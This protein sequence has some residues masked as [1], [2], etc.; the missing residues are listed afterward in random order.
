MKVVGFAGWSNSGKTTLITG[1]IAA[2]KAGGARVSVVKHAHQR[3]DIDHPGKDSWR[4]R[5]AGAYEVLIASGRRM[6]KMRE[7]EHEM[8]LDVHALL[9]ELDAA[10]WV[11]VEGFRHADLPKI[12]VWREGRADRGALYPDDPFV[13]AIATDTVLPEPTQ[14]P[15]LPLGDPAAV[16]AWLLGNA[17]RFDY[18]P[19]HHG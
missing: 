11:L 5:E 16:A 4:H 9:A 8:D 13:C 6:A 12:E 14:R 7:F 2:L 19:L 17:T 18:H 3:F 15:V 1:V 10:D